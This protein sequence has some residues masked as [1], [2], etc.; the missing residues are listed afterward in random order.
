[1]SE[2]WRHIV[3]FPGYLVSDQGRVYNTG[4]VITRAGSEP[5]WEDGKCWRGT[6]PHPVKIKKR[7]KTIFLH[8]GRP[9]VMLNKGGKLYKF[10]VIK[11]M[12]EAFIGETPS[13]YEV[14]V[15]N[16][17]KTDCVLSN[18]YYKVYELPGTKAART[19]KLQR[20]S[21]ERAR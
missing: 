8:R 6:Q 5:D 15:K 20:G 12:A 1:M 17:V 11:L 4:P 7:Y 21:L 9:H 14:E 18:L 10:S 13:G 3:D 19:K 2:R 16:G